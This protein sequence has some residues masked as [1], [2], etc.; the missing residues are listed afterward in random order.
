MEYEGKD[1]L[2]GEKENTYY[3]WKNIRRG[4]IKLK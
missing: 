3:N 1:Y 2:F 4:R